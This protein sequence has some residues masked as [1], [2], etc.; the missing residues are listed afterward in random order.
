MDHP[1]VIRGLERGKRP[2]LVISECQ[3]GILDREFAGLPN[4]VDQ[5]EQRG[6]LARIA[7]LAD[8]FRRR[9]LPVVHAHISHRPG[10]V[11]NAMTSPLA[12]SVRRTGGLVEGTAQ[13][14]SMPEVAPQTGDLVSARRSGLAMWYGTDLDVTLRNLHVDTIVLAGVSTNIALFGGSLG[15]VERGY[16]AVIPENCSAGGTAD[17]HRFMV[18]E[19]LPLLA[20]MTDLDGVVSALGALGAD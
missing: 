3:R 13:A 7:V 16:Q 1:S 19:S 17:S 11:G 8:E 20:S 15:A 5:V 10:L 9:G 4:L 6:I 14:A 18:T 2:A 12:A